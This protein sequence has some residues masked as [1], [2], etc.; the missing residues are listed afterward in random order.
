V[1][2][3]LGVRIVCVCVCVCVC[4][5]EGVNVWL[6]AF[7]DVYFGCGCQCLL[8][9]HRLFHS[10]LSLRVHASS[11]LDIRDA[12]E[13]FVRAFEVPEA[14][15]QCYLLAAMNCHLDVFFDT[16]ERISGVPKPWLRLPSFVAWYGAVALDTVNRNLRYAFVCL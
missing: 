12:A 3:C 7:V 5:G 9:S 6:C 15:G 4:V 13:A 11:Y 1:C 14:A 8:E 16:L 10:F 2:V